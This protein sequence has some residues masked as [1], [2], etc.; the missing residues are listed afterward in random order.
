MQNIFNISLSLEQHLIYKVFL[1]CGC[2]GVHGYTPG[3]H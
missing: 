3:G 1:A 2:D